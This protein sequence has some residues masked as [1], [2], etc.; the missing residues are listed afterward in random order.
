MQTYTENMSPTKNKNNSGIP[1]DL[2]AYYDEPRTTTRAWARWIIRV[3][4][5]V[6]LVCLAIMLVKWTWHQ[7]HTDTDKKPKTSTSQKA[8][9]DANSSSPITLGGSSDGQTSSDSSTSAEGNVGSA[10]S[11]T[12]SA[13]S[14]S[15]SSLTNT[16][17]GS[18]VAIFV[19][20]SLGFAALYEL[21]LR[22]SKK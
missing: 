3:L 18:T 19:A 22:T 5:V 14:T 20:A 15:T 2:Q 1:A 8:G 9:S 12:G 21:R 13:A 17:P 11:T 6:I 10:A 16:G 4:A 7:T